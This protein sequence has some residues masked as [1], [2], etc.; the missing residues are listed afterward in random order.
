MIFL[1]LWKCGMGRTTLTKE[2]CQN[3]GKKY[4]PTTRKLQIVTKVKSEVERY[5]VDNLGGILLIGER[6][7]GR[8]GAPS[9]VTRSRS[10]ASPPA[11]S[12][13]KTKSNLISIVRRHLTHDIIKCINIV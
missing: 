11:P 4:S 13:I 6:S 5:F 3:H 12:P 8:G 7:H 1:L 9:T 10:L 2:I